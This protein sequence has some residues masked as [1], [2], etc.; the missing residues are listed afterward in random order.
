M[1][2]I[3]A[4]L[5]NDTIIIKSPR[6]LSNTILKEL[7]NWEL[8]TDSSPFVYSIKAFP[9]N[10]FVIFSLMYKS[11]GI[12]ENLD[13]SNLLKINIKSVTPP[14]AFLQ[15]ESAIGINVPD[16]NSYLQFL[17]IIGAKQV[18]MGL[19][20]IPFSRLYE[21]YKLIESWQHPFLPPIKIHPDLLN[22]VTYKLTENNDLESL[23][24]T[25]LTELYSIYHGYQIKFD[26]FK[27]LKYEH[28]SDLLLRRPTRYI[29]RTDITDFT[30]AKF[31]KPALVKGTIQKISS[32]FNNRL[33]VHL[34]D[35]RNED[36]IEISFFAGGYLSRVYSPGDVVIIDLLK[37]G[38]FSAN[39]SAI[40]PLIEV[41]TNPILPVYR[42]APS[43]KIT[44]KVLTN[45]VNELF[46]RFDG[47]KI[48][49]YIKTIDK[50]LWE[51]LH[52]LHFP[53]DVNSY[54]K[55]LDQLAYIELVYLQLLF[56][57]KRKN[58]ETREGVSKS[59]TTPTLMKSAIDALPYELTNG[60]KDAI[61]HIISRLRT[62]EYQD[63][64]LSGDVGS[65]K[66]S[67]AQAACLY[68]VDSGYQAALV[69]PTEILA[70]QLY[71]TFLKLIAPLE[72]KPT[73]VY[74]SGNTKAAEKKKIL[75]GIEDGSINIIVGT[76]G[77][78]NITEWD[79]LGLIVI[80][81]Q[82]KFGAAQREKLLYSRKDGKLPD[83]LAQTATPIPRSTALAFYGDIDLITLTEKPNN[84]KENI[85]KWIKSSTDD[86]LKDITSPTWGHIF[87][88]IQ[89]GRQ[90]FIVTPAVSE[91]AK[92]AS[93]KKV[94]KILEQQFPKIKIGKVH[95]QMTKE[96]QNKILEEF[97]DEKY[98]VLIA[99]S[100]IE[101]GI[102]VPNSTIILV[103]D[104]ERFGASSLHQ[105]RGRVGRSHHQ[106][107]CY[108]ISDKDNKSTSKR[109]GALV[110]SNNGFDIA[111]VDLETRKE[112]DIL[113][114]RQSGESS[115]IFCDLADHTKLIDLARQEAQRIYNSDDRELAL[116]DATTFLKKG[117]E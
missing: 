102:D 36:G 13:I 50:T 17:S 43:S 100:V 76:H 6:A 59:S 60:Q 3:L 5:E 12:F 106:G 98:E 15:G 117:E 56:I 44:T 9:Y 23:F 103:L 11:P 91:G 4:T 82:Q 89:D 14:K 28:A 46:M 67:V 111:L 72:N 69:G 24:S 39:G 114:T 26:G 68:T 38:K 19:W 53:K 37:T 21:A 61:K 34:V 92:M 64:L 99:S 62:N 112:G 45:C 33:I 73:I 83:L 104:A 57:D 90:I 74:L 110:E 116:K 105:I 32:T 8:T 109:L 87:K 54:M 7:T 97:R 27:K 77:V 66:T 42:Q 55:T 40:I 93:V 80:D 20:T 52:D 115:L 96:K 63:I 108:L 86:F 94:A 31:W 85:T 41:E 75:K 10:C 101:V 65:G 88:E 84:R 113:G 29:D 95:G 79:N 30:K 2:K 58:T 1:N 71:E 48:G 47:S 78:F 70:K 16:I 51:L 25:E 81:E 22:L 35:T 18:R 49:N 107:Y